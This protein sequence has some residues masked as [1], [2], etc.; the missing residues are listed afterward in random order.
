MLTPH[1]FAPTSGRNK[2]ILIALPPS[3]LSE[4]DFIAQQEHRSRSDLVRESLRR[5]VDNFRAQ[6]HHQE[7]LVSF[8][9]PVTVLPPVA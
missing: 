6:R 8:A 1:T 2:K 3:M 4:C 7:G 9:P 5:Y